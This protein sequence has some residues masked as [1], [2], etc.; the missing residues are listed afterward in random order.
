M[1]FD[2]AYKAK[3]VTDEHIDAAVEEFLND[4]TPGTCLLTE[5][6]MID[7]CAIIDANAPA[8]EV[9]AKRNVSDAEM[10]IAVKTAIL[11]APV[12]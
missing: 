8:R 7:V 4:P 9:L 3:L 2:E 1:T 5:S 11:L 6:I 12:G 10:R